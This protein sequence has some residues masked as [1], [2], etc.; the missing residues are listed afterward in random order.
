M[1]KGKTYT[2]FMC[3]IIKRAFIEFRRARGTYFESYALHKAETT[4]LRRKC[5]K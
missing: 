5:M 2:M 4:N 1:T 3:T